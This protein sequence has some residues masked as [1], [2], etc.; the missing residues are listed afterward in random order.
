[1]KNEDEK[2]RTRGLASNHQKKTK[3]VG[4]GFDAMS[5]EGN[6]FREGKKARSLKYTRN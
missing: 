1:L 5:T 6:D 3:Q 4:Q 2:V